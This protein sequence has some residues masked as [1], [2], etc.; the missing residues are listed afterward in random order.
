MMKSIRIIQATYQYKI[1]LLGDEMEIW[2]YLKKYLGLY[3]TT[4]YTIGHPPF[5]QAFKCNVTLP[6]ETSKNDWGSGMV[7][8]TP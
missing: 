7:G 3:S 8:S 4:K 1:V 6:G 5:S 2:I